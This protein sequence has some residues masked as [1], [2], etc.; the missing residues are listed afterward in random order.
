[1]KHYITRCKSGLFK[2]E[3]TVQLNSIFLWKT[4]CIAENPMSGFW[5]KDRL[6]FHELRKP[7][8]SVGRDSEFVSHD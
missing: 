3:E 7:L 2:H 4:R 6:T 8:F 5:K 1:M